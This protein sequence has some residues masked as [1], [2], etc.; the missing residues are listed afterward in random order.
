MAIELKAILDDKEFQAALGRMIKKYGDAGGA[1]K[2]AGA[3]MDDSVDKQARK[4]ES[5]ASVYA[6][7][8]KGTKQEQQA[9]KELN[10]SR[11]Q[12]VEKIG[13]SAR[14]IKQFINNI[15]L[16]GVGFRVMQSTLGTLHQEFAKTADEFKTVDRATYIWNR[17]LEKLTGGPLSALTEMFTSLSLGRL[18]SDIEQEAASTDKRASGVIARNRTRDVRTNRE[19][20]DDDG[21]VTNRLSNEQRFTA[22]TLARHDAVAGIA[23]TTKRLTDEER[24]QHEVLREITD[25]AKRLYETNTL[26]E[27]KAKEIAARQQAILGALEQSVVA[28]RQIER[29]AA[30]QLEAYRNEERFRMSAVEATQ[31]L[32]ELEQ[33]RADLV[34]KGQLNGERLAKHQREVAAATAAIVAAERDAAEFQ[35]S[36]LRTQRD[37]AFAL[38]TER[39]T[40]EQLVSMQAEFAATAVDQT[41]NAEQRAEAAQRSQTIEQQLAQIRREDRDI[42]KQ[43]AAIAGDLNR[44]KEL[45][46]KGETELIRLRD[47]AL[48]KMKEMNTTADERA[49]LAK[50]ALG[51]EQKIAEL[52]REQIAA[53]KELDRLARDKMMAA[54]K[55]REDAAKANSDKMLELAKML[56]VKGGDGAATAQ[57]AGPQ[58]RR[59]IFG[60]ILPGMMM[61]GPGIMRG[62][63]VMGPIG[64]PTASTPGTEGM[65]GGVGG[66]A[67]DAQRRAESQ[68]KRERRQAIEAERD[69]QRR[70][71][72]G[73]D[74]LSADEKK[75]AFRRAGSD[76][77]DRMKNVGRNFK[78]EM[79]EGGDAAGEV[80]T[81]RNDI[82]QKTMEREGKAMG[83]SK[84]A[85][86]AM[87]KFM[88]E[89]MKREKELEDQQK[90]IGV[91]EELVNAYGQAGVQRAMNGGRR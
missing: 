6:S 19:A 12:S 55:A 51:A 9:T 3:A 17:S 13:Q 76:A 89:G 47:E 84:Q 72:M 14:N 4:L 45:E 11:L 22:L 49:D 70:K 88:Q 81:R 91:L 58:R 68:I 40:I 5:L 16:A 31:R 32:V 43:I 46:N 7:F 24:N 87:N 10:D 15:A 33:E 69:R 77:D 79:A 39:A 21:K 67:A 30:E 78:K 85:I 61:Q 1:A 86:D 75:T 52:K 65:E 60:G 62:P 83:L 38:D 28:S 71:V 37:M 74:S 34:N 2:K 54:Q 36:N 57:I 59:G 64:L 8:M 44:E 90:R 18:T 80:E 48:G 23:A 27:S 56:G 29:S 50:K 53:D 20:E 82:M 73:D 35:K 66:I 41:K 25:E 26:T 63:G 42:Q